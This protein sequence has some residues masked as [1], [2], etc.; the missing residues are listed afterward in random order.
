M[1]I[2]EFS[3]NLQKLY[4]EMDQTFSPYQASTGLHCL[5]GCG[6]CCMNPEVEA[7]LLEMLP[8]ALRVLDEGTLNEW[9]DKLEN[10]QQDFCV[11]FQNEGEGRGKCGSYQDRP[12]VC[13]MFGVAGYFDKHHQVTLSICK[14]IQEMDTELSEKMKAQADQENTPM[15]MLWSSQMAVLNPD[16]IQN[17]MLINMAIK[18]ALAKVALYAMYQS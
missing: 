2:R 12:S 7:S 3:L 18:E 5:P 13:R 14:Y 4:Q 6:R 8:F 1:N 11:L 17:K 9:M 16:L 15:L 10:N